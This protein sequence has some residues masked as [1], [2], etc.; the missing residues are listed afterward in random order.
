MSPPGRSG[1]NAGRGGNARFHAAALADSTARAAPMAGCSPARRPARDR[2]SWLFFV[3]L[4]HAA[5][6]NLSVPAL[7]D[8]QSLPDD[9]AGRFD[10]LAGALQA[11]PPAEPSCLARLLHGVAECDAQEMGAAP[12]GLPAT[13][14]ALVASLRAL[15]AA[16]IPL[17]TALRLAQAPDGY[18]SAAAQSAFLRL[19]AARP[20]LQPRGLWPTTSEQRCPTVDDTDLALAVADAEQGVRML[21]AVRAARAMASRPESHNARAPPTRPP[22]TPVQEDARQQEAEAG[23]GQAAMVHR[24]RLRATRPATPPLSTKAPTQLR[25]PRRRARARCACAS[26]PSVEEPVC[27]RPSARSSETRVTSQQSASPR[28]DAP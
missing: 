15:P 25:P 22:R 21:M 11:A 24:L 12:L 2:N 20:W 18:V 26:C 19:M 1:P 3:P 17:A 6:G 9:A 4:L 8:W 14:A 23:N 16:P 7:A 10:T 13:D 27:G 28:R 5:T